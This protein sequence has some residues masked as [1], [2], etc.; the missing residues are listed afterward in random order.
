MEF[1]HKSSDWKGQSA[2]FA[3]CW[4]DYSQT[5]DNFVFISNLIILSK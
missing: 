3:A 2:R 1:H 4:W 5:K